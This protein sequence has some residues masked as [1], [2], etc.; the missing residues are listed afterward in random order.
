MN[1]REKNKKTPVAIDLTP[2]I[3]AVFLLLIFFAVTTTFIATPGIRVD[4]PG[5]KSASLQRE[6]RELVITLTKEGEI[7]FEREFVSLKALEGILKK[8]P[9]EDKKLMVIVRADEKVEHGRVIAVLDT[10]RSCGFKRIA[11]ATRKK[12]E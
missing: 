11:L 5:A 10:I 8:L 12:E 2:L 1:F 6:K 3:D 9:L 7:I 4:L